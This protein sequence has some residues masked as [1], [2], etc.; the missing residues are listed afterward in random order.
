M[1]DI[2]TNQV[3]ANQ[4]TNSVG[5]TRTVGEYK[6]DPLERE[7][8]LFARFAELMFHAIDDMSDDLETNSNELDKVEEMSARMGELKTDAGKGTTHMPADMGN[9]LFAR[10]IRTDRTGGDNNHTA[11]EWDVNKG[12]L[13]SY[14]QSHMNIGTLKLRKLEALNGKARNMME[15]ASAADKSNQNNKSSIIRNM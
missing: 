8:M 2:N 3:G 10:G 5:S 11:A 13:E 7:A 9:F 14:R 15:A 1:T 12:Y 6:L 4:P